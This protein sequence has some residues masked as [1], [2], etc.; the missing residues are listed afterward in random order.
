MT[1]RGSERLGEHHAGDHLA[2]EQIEAPDR[3][4]VAE[5]GGLAVPTEEMRSKILRLENPD[6]ASGCVVRGLETTGQ[7]ATRLR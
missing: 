6:D 2:H 1:S 3:K 4:A 7:S 5:G